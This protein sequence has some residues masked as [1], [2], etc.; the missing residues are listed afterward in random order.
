MSVDYSQ[1]YDSEDEGTNEPDH[2]G[3]CNHRAAMFFILPSLTCCGL[4]ITLFAVDMWFRL[5]HTSN[6]GYDRFWG[7]LCRGRRARGG[8]YVVMG[9]R[10]EL[11]IV[12]LSYRCILSVPLVGDQV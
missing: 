12:V 1:D 8:V 3:C 10:V 9:M 2:E 4:N 7:V 11:D 5:E 6:R